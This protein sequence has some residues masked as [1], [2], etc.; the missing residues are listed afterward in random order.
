[1]IIFFKRKFID[2]LSSATANWKLFTFSIADSSLDKVMINT[3]GYR[4]TPHF[5]H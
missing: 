4:G 1:M 5:M 2:L 3:I